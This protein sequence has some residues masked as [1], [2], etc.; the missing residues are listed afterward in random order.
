MSAERGVVVEHPQ[1]ERREH[2]QRQQSPIWSQRLRD[3]EPPSAAF[4]RDDHVDDPV[5]VLD[6]GLVDE[7]S[8]EDKALDGVIFAHQDHRHHQRGAN[9][10]QLRLI[11]QRG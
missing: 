9:L 3:D 4:L 5:H 10:K 11:H 6:G 8:H 7:E 2:R 1:E